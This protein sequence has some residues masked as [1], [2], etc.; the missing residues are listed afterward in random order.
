MRLKHLRN[1]K[2]YMQTYMLYMNRQINMI[3]AKEV[4]F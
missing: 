3:S 1:L 2:V 4:N